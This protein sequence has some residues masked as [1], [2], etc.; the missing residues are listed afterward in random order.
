[1]W[2]TN[3]RKVQSGIV[4]RAKYE[5]HWDS[6]RLASPISSRL[7]ATI[8]EYVALRGSRPVRLL[9]GKKQGEINCTPQLNILRLASGHSDVINWD[10]RY[11]LPPWPRRRRHP[12]GA[13][14]RLSYHP[15]AA[16]KA[17]R[18]VCFIRL[19]WKRSGPAPQR[20]FGDRLRQRLGAGLCFRRDCPG[21]VAY[22]QRGRRGRGRYS[23]LS[24]V[25]VSGGPN[26][27]A[28]K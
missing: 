3:A 24:R 26:L 5:I 20:D 13:L 10:T 9:C 11:A 4:W 23:S 12:T 21:T 25:N 2:R 16:S 17:R 14:S 1:M 27:L 19:R 7:G 6:L 22:R 8:A 28:L 18:P 15:T